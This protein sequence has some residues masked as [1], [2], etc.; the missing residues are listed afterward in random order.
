MTPTSMLDAERDRADRAV[1][2]LDES[3]D[4]LARAHVGRGHDR[5]VLAIVTHDLRSPLC[6]ISMNAQHIAESSTEASI[7]R[8]PAM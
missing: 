1:F 7:R 8:W 2:A 4:S 6:V 5:D 3:K